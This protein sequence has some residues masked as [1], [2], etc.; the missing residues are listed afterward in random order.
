MKIEKIKHILKLIFVKLIF[1]YQGL[2]PLHNAS[3]YGHLDIAALL[4]KHTSHIN[5]PD[6]WGTN[7][8]VFLSVF[9]SL[10]AAATV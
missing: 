8:S 9:C 3:S 2:I 6:K 7:S 5:I 4:I 1:A 10:I